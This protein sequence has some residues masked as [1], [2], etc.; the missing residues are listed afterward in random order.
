MTKQEQKQFFKKYYSDYNPKRHDA[1]V[2]R[3]VEEQKK[4]ALNDYMVNRGIIETIQEL[5]PWGSGWSQHSPM[6]RF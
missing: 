4:K 1:F 6:P 2:L 3:Y 5:T